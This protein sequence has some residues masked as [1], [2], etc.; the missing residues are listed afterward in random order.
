MIYVE[1]ARNVITLT[2]MKDSIMT[3]QNDKQPNDTKHC[4][5]QHNN[6]KD[7]DTQL[8][9]LATLIIPTLNY[10]KVVQQAA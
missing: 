10:G 1:I 5:T 4:D 3:K 8:G 7:N 2:K 6:T 9:S